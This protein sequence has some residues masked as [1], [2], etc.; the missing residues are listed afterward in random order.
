VWV[1]EDNMMIRRSLFAVVALAVFGSGAACSQAADEDDASGELGQSPDEVREQIPGPVVKSTDAEVWSADNQWADTNTP[2]AKKA[3]V[4]WGANSGLSWEEKYRKWVGTF[5]KVDARPNGYGKTIR[6]TTPYGKTVDGPVLEC[7]DVGIWLRMTFSALYHLPFYLTGF[8]NGKTIYMGHMGVVDK[9]G[10]PVSGFPLF[11]A[12]YKDFEGRWADGQSWPSDPQLRASHVGQD[13]S[14]EG[15]KIGDSET[16]AAADG[17]GAYMDEL[18]LNK[19]VGW[20]QHYLDAYFGSAN[21]ADG[22]N[23]FHIT[24][25][26]VSQGDLLLERWQKNGIG[27]TLPVMT[28]ITLPN[29]KMRVSVASG[30]MPRRQPNWEDEGSSANYFKSDNCGGVGNTWGDDAVPLA[31][32]G[33]G[34]R[35]WRTPIIRSGRWSND[36]PGVDHPFYIEDTNLDAISARPLK[37]A[38]LLAEDTPEGARDAA[39]ATIDSARRSLHDHP[40]SCSARTKREDAFK[41]LYAVMKNSFQKDQAAVDKEYR[42]LEDYVYAELEYNASKT[43]CWNSTTTKMNDL[44]LEFAEKEKETND[45][46]KVCKNP[47]VFKASGG[48]KYDTWKT[49]AATSGKSADWK[50]WSEDEPCAQKDAAEDKLGTRGDVKMVCDPFP[51]D[52][53]PADPPADPPANP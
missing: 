3:G 48:G 6:I 5:T 26:A 14:E 20:L 9:D 13:D 33:G 2:N 21:L 50:D 22:A 44:I 8:D 23:M 36:V 41:E 42:Q 34:I 16:L 38:Q 12:R 52:S 18:F 29:G 11:K 24:P 19:R 25:E 15:V 28:S 1:W 35:R 4:N 46:A 49:Y 17:A 37:F 51:T 43:C 53:P 45:A 10:N 47:T 39:L 27:H 31:K 40:A 32:L 7:A 30:S